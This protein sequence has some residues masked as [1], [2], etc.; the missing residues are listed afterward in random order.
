MNTND[1]TVKAIQYLGRDENHKIN[2]MN[3]VQYASKLEQELAEL[4]AKPD[5]LEWA[6]EHFAMISASWC[7]R[8]LK[9]S[10]GVR[11]HNIIASSP[12]ELVEK[13]RKELEENP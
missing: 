3:I 5:P 2:G 13:G 7:L 12:T 10:N 4:K 1:E 8:Y 11:R 6:Q 9:D